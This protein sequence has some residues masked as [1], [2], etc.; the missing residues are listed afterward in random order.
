[1]T[2]YTKGLH[3]VADHVWGWLAPDGSWG[4]SNAGLIEGDRASFLVDTLFDLPLTAE[5]LAAMS[6]ITDRSPITDALNTH[7]NGDHCY[8]NQLLAPEVRIHATPLCRHEI[9]DVPPAML[10]QL[11]TT[12]LGPELTPYVRRMFGAFDFSDIT[13]REPDAGFETEATVTAGGREVRL[14][15]LGPAH[16]GGDAVAYVPD[17][18]VVFAG[19]LLFIGGTPVTWSGDLNG[20]IAACDTM[21]GWD[22]AVVV[23]G[24]GPVTDASGVLEVR[25][26]LTHVRDGLDASIRA[27]WSWQEAADRI[28][29]GPYAR[30]PDSE[31]IVITA[32]NVYR[33]R[34]VDQ[35]ESS[36]MDLVVQMSAWLRGRD[37]ALS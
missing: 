11:T 35:D 6:E 21:V 4:W 29:L 14:V 27:G 34:G 10:H 31:R 7:A 32:Y 13:L 1:M 5:M 22:P 16:T 33:T 25:G 36:V 26:Y 12:D 8:G 24:H 3:E 2:E 18:G 20:W 37:A 28:D 30:L 17:A 19:D 9:H 23:P 15:P